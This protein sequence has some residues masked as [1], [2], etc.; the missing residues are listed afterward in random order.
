L[1]SGSWIV[2]NLPVWLTTAV[3]LLIATLT[4]FGYRAVVGWRASATLVANR[5]AGEMANLLVGAI[6][7]DMR[8]VQT[9]VLPSLHAGEFMLDAPYDVSD[10][11]ASAFARY[12]YPESFFAWRGVPAPES[13]VFLDRADRLPSWGQRGG[14][15]SR[16]PVVVQSHP[17][18]A[19]LL[20]ERIAVDAAQGH[21]FSTFD[22][23]LDG[24][25]Y[26]VVTRLLYRDQLREQLD[27]AF[28][29][30]V[31]LS[32]VRAHYFNDL[33]HQVARIGNASGLSLFVVDEQNRRIAAVPPAALSGIAVRR[34]FP[35]SFFDPV[36]VQ[37]DANAR[38]WAVA[39]GVARDPTLAQAVRA[40]DRTLLML[41]AATAALA[42]G[43]ALTLRATRKTAQLA[44]IRSDFVST[45]THELK[46]P[47][48]TIRAIGDTLARG[49]ISDA[50]ARLEYAQLIVQESKRLSRLV[51]NLLAYSRITDVTEVYAL[52]T[53][54]VRSMVDDA[55]RGFHTQLQE[56]RFHVRVDVAPDLPLRADPAAMILMFDNIVDNAIRYSAAEH[57]IE[58][59]GRRENGLAIV[60]VRDRGIGIPADEIA[61][62][63]RRF[64]RSPGTGSGGSGLG[65]AIV[66]RI[67]ADHGGTVSIESRVG[68]GT[69]VRLALPVANDD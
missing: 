51:D 31:N 55:L 6:M 36:V 35:M 59:V 63:T 53:V 18:I 60:E 29:F 68:R 9:V 5:R 4:W 7:R 26:Q 46:T 48:A 67:V 19:R 54:E 66:K 58:I 10:I 27:A 57:V 64:Y 8:G 11:A 23:T 69:T 34:E 3:L 65:L 56:K 1:K 12:P 42:V 2:R 45:V 20:I 43:L 52:E 50:E 39:V 28:G 30:T 41:A 38:L 21:R 15:T 25:P 49:R 44:E 13:V 47:I 22:L 32:W 33:T 61:R 17:T 16:F 40:S 37:H 14:T 24:V 62:V